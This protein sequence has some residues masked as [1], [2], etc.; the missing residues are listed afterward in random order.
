MGYTTLYGDA[1][2]SMSVL[3]DLLKREV[4]KLAHFINRNE[5]IIPKNV[6]EKA[7]TAEL[8]HNQ[9][10]QDTLPEYA[11]LD[12]IV[13]EFVV[14]AK[15]ADWIA[16]EHGFDLQLVQDV[17]NKIHQNEYKRR[18]APLQLRVSSKAFSC[19]RRIPIVHHFY[20]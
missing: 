18:Q 1:C 16:K 15:S 3:G 13:D 19:G 4:Y 14:H 11:V 9:K 10:D 7:P 20:S 12:T 6:F 8:K 17:C 5:E 2:G